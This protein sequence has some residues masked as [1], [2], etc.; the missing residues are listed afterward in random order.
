MQ[1]QRL[2]AMPDSMV[3]GIRAAAR[4]DALFFRDLVARGVLTSS[5]AERDIGIP[6]D[7]RQALLRFAREQ[8]EET[9]WVRS[10]LRLRSETLMEFRRQMRTPTR[11]AA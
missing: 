1:G 7:V 11:A 8:P 3:A 2:R 9:W 5:Q 10:A 6:R 4:A